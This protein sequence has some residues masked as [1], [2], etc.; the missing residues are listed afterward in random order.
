MPSNIFP[1]RAA[2]RG[3]LGTLTLEQAAALREK[4]RRYL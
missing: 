3:L 1:P 4:I 2:R